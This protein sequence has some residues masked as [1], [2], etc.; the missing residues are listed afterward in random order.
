MSKFKRGKYKPDVNK[1]SILLA[2]QSST[3]AAYGYGSISYKLP[4]F[5]LIDFGNKFNTEYNIF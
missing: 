5:Q 4:L 1:K 2:S 3:E